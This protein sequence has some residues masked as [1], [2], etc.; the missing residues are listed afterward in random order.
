[1]TETETLQ[2]QLRIA[3]HA[4]EAFRLLTYPVSKEIKPKGFSWMY[5]PHELS[6]TLEYVKEQIDAALQQ[7]AE[8]KGEM[9]DA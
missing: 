2:E 7:I 4:L 5:N 3:V 8:L 6:E 1:M 9:K